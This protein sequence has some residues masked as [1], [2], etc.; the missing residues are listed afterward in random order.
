[1]MSSDVILKSQTPIS[2]VFKPKTMAGKRK[3]VLGCHISQLLNGLCC[4]IYKREIT[5]VVFRLKQRLRITG[6][7]EVERDG[8]TS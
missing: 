8:E 6:E 2:H 7:K 5:V 1:M 3:N 4:I